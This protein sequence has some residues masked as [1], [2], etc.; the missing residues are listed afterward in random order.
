MDWKQGIAGIVEKYAQGGAT[1]T[2]AENPHQD[3]QQ[4]AQ[5]AP[6][7]VVASGL[8]QAFR[9]NQTPPFPEMVAKLFGQSDANQR[10]GLLNHLLGS[11]SPGSFRALPG[12]GSLAGMLQSRNVSPDQANQVAPQQV[13]QIAA[14]AERH[15]PSIVDEVS[16][17]YAQHPD[18]VKAI[19]GLAVSIALQHMLRPR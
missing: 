2:A 13:Q 1:T 11:F 18:I 19:G 4:A 16:S 9:S 10:A 17:F 5:A 15:N 8:S 14:H 12:L 7:E 3:F 6:K